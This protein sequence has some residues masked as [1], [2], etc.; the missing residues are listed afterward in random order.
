MSDCDASPAAADRVVAGQGFQLQRDAGE[1]FWA[2]RAAWRSQNQSHA[3]DLRLHS[4][5]RDFTTQ[6]ATFNGW[7][8]GQQ[9]CPGTMAFSALPGHSEHQTGDAIDIDAWALDN[10]ST[11]PTNATLATFIETQACKYGFVRSYP[12][13]GMDTTGYD[14]E[15]W[16]WRYVGRERAMFMRYQLATGTCA[17]N[18]Q[19][20]EEYF[21]EHPD[22]VDTGDCSDCPVTSGAAA[23]CLGN[24]PP[25]PL[26]PTTPPPGCPDCTTPYTPPAPSTSV[27]VA[28][29]PEP[30]PSGIPTTRFTSGSISNYVRT[31]PAGGTVRIE[32][33]STHPVR[34]SEAGLFEVAAG[35]TMCLTFPSAGTYPMFETANGWSGE[36]QVTAP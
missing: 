34:S 3:I 17:V 10:T 6:V 2:M 36:V 26:P 28:A 35:T 9:S 24:L 16:H 27:T 33:D 30:L 29:C 7:F 23:T 20:L 11:T 14:Q 15:P 31:I 12:F 1:A 22:E 32:N 25:L 8:S 5:L 21:A 18:G 4:A 13:G 19:T